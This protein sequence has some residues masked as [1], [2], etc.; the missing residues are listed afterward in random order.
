LSSFT[1]TIPAYKQE[2]EVDR[3]LSRKDH[4]IALAY[5]PSKAQAGDFIYLVF[6]GR[7]VGR[8]RIS[9][10]DAVDRDVPSGTGRTPAWAKW[11]V[12]YAGG[13]EKP[14]R[15]IPVQGHQSIRYLKT[16]A[17]EHLDFETW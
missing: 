13:W 3:T 10:I 17:L 14:P 9:S 11:I 2:E 1:R 5:Q 6:K 15:E 12:R 8:A 7:I 16:H 4:F